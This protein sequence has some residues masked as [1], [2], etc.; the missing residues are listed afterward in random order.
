MNYKAIIFFWWALH[1]AVHELAHVIMTILC[2]PLGVRVTNFSI[3]ATTHD[4]GEG[5]TMIVGHNSTSQFATMLVAVAPLLFYYPVLILLFIKGKIFLYFFMLLG[6]KH[7]WL[8][9]QDKLI[10]IKAFKSSFIYR[11][12]DREK[13]NYQIEVLNKEQNVKQTDTTREKIDL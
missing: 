10:F 6:Q 9:K 5:Y 11:M 8:S 12:Y 7:Y 3:K 1:G 13:Y 2:Y 4:T